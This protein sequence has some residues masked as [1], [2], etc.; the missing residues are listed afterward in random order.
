MSSS[1]WRR[2][3]VYDVKRRADETSGMDAGSCNGRKEREL[4]MG[5]G[6]RKS[7][8]NAAVAVLV[9]VLMGLLG[10]WLLVRWICCV[11]AGFRNR[12]IEKQDVRKVKSGCGCQIK[13]EKFKV[14]GGP[15]RPLGCFI[16]A[17]SMSISSLCATPSRA[18]RNAGRAACAWQEQ[19]WVR[20]RA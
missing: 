20:H 8:G 18:L 11:R 7:F 9:L 6:T 14:K 12:G 15:S 10:C 4:K 19:R 3:F 13:K 17:K 16:V 2:F 5:L 1:C